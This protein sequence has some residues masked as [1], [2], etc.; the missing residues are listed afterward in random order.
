MPARAPE[1]LEATTGNACL[2][3]LA[4]VAW[5]SVLIASIAGGML[6]GRPAIAANEEPVKLADTQLEPLDWS[7][8]E[9]WRAT[10]TSRHS[11]RTRPA[12]RHCARS[13]VPTIT[14]QFFAVWEAC[15]KALPLQPADSHAARTFF[16]QNSC[17]CASPAWGARGFVTGYYEP[18]VAG[19]RFPILSFTSRCTGVRAT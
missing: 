17:R 15:R 11:R 13:R 5:L 19:S 4:R 1:R 10:I 14:G 7:A 16:E 2:R 12:A 9:G 8:V 18:V 3:A 6:Y